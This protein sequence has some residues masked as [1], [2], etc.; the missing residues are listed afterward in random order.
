MGSTCVAASFR[1][2]E[3]DR[4]SV[5]TISSEFYNPYAS[6][7]VIEGVETVCSVFKTITATRNAVRPI[8]LSQRKALPDTPLLLDHDLYRAIGEVGLKAT[9]IGSIE[10]SFLQLD[11]SQAA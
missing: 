7:F 1:I 9:I 6:R 4:Q 8:Q 3:F 5:Q 10:T 2:I 11:S